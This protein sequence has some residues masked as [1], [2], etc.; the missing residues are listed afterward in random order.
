MGVVYKAEDTEL[1][2]FVALKFLPEDVAK[3]PQTLERFR[4]EARAASA[5]NHP[6]ICTIYEISK[7]DAQYF[8]VMELLEGK[9]LRDCIVGKPLPTDQLL[10]LAVEIAEGLSAAHAKGIIHRDIKPGN[11]FVT[12]RA[13]A[14][15]LD[16]GLA[17]VAS[18]AHSSPKSLG[19]ALT[20]VSELHLTSPGTA[21][22]T[23]A[24]MSPEQASGDEL[25]ART[26]LFSFGAVLYEMATG[27]PAFS[28]GTTAK[29]FDA[30]LNRAP[31]APVR[32][33]PALPSKFE[34]IINKALEKDRK[35]RY[36]NAGD[37]AV[38]LKRLRREID[39]G[40]ISATPVYSTVAPAAV[41]PTAPMRWRSRRKSVTIGAFA[42]VGIAVLGWFLRP[43]LPPPKVKNF[44]QIT[45]DGWQ[46][47]FFGQVAPTVLT[48]GPRLYI[49]E[50]VKGSFV[51]AQVSIAGGETVQIPTPFPNVALDN[52]S[53]DRSELVVGSFSGTEVDQPLWTLPM[54]GG[55]PRRLTGLPGEDATW[56]ANGDLLVS[57]GNELTVVSRDGAAQSKFLTV[58]DTGLA[59]YFLRWSP[60]GRVLR[61]TVSPAG[62]NFLA[63]VS[64]DG[65][66]Y[67]RILK[68]W[69]PADDLSSGNWTPD[70]KYFLFQAIHNGRADI[71]AIQQ[72]GD[73]FHKASQEPMQL[74]A[75]PLS[76][77]APQP[78]LDG[79]KLFVIGEQLRA[80][81]VR[82]DAKSSQFLPYLGGISARGVNFSHD[83]KWASYVSYPEGDLW[84]CRVDG[85]EKLQLTS[86]PLFVDDAH[87]SP[88]GR[89]IAFTAAQ[90]GKLRR[91]YLVAAEGGTPHEVPAGDA[92]VLNA[93]WAP[94]GKSVTFIDFF[95]SNHSLIRSVDLETLKVSTL[96]E[97]RDLGFIAAR[98]P[99]G[100]YLA[101]A[102]TANQKLVLYDFMTEKWS[103]LASISIG[104]IGWSPD[105][106]HVYFDNG[107]TGDPAIY[108]VRVA[109]HKLERLASLKEFRRVVT[110]VIPWTGFT[111]EGDP[112]LMQDAGTQEVYALDFETP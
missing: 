54:L 20:V 23:I 50:N 63:E 16:F 58:G 1:G 38:D 25:D 30:I 28:G 87:W 70:G 72:K 107:Y 51:I 93:S 85:S 2:R 47:N 57:H 97:S 46:K 5:L 92:N 76:F 33:N 74:T 102:G 42:L 105:G 96:P 21:V 17:K 111:P 14:K 88:D 56:M 84:R 35:L 6:N 65:S 7:H 44:T 83:G 68:D 18:E 12:E 99:V 90:P 9:T 69:H 73:L 101:V 11:I 66:N 19:A 31:L 10:D 3:D 81:L 29:V 75:G 106:Q 36:Q 108:R 91:L 71:W 37:M 109:D 49:Q 53:P 112:L 24:Y 43:A 60:D 79:K 82:Y 77:Y 95:G 64:A 78:S 59:A 100:H 55:S 86:E 48:D 104:S 45:H 61:F 39:S 4:R 110:P 26:D 80:E 40:R 34:E 89:Q 27:L 32:L 98:S 62:T 52:M 67:H 41:T 94:D 103:Q 15:I 8:I 13:H 22:G